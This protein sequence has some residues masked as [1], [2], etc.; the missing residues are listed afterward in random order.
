MFRLISSVLFFIAIGSSLHATENQMISDCLRR[1]ISNID[2]AQAV[3]LVDVWGANGNEV[4]ENQLSVLHA[5][6][7][8]SFPIFLVEYKCK[9]DERIYGFLTEL[10]EEYPLHMITKTTTDA[11]F[12]TGLSDL[13][14]QYGITRLVIMGGRTNVCIKHTI[15]SG[16]E[17]G[18]KFLGAP[19]LLEGGFP[20]YAIDLEESFSL[21]K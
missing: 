16:I 7:E 2:N 5:A 14:N 3:L 1:L 20:A 6:V 18:F 21:F 13:F 11:F 10:P 15:F 19:N 4:I 12:E 9:T 17:L 8:R